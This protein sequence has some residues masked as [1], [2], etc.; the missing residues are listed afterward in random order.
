[1][2]NVLADRLAVMGITTIDSLAE[3]SVDELLV[4]PDLTAEQAGA[5][6][7]KARESWFH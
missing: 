3:L 5:L 4:I 6:I 7:M 1:M 2:T